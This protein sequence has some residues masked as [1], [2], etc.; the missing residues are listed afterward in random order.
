M[1]VAHAKDGGACLQT[2]IED[3][4]DGGRRAGKSEADMGRLRPRTVEWE[5]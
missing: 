3:G 5:K 2:G 4:V 1:D